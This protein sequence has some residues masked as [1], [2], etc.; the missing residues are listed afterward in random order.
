MKI[1]FLF[2]WYDLWVGIFYDRKNRWIY[3]L[4]LPTVGIILK[5]PTPTIKKLNIHDVSLSVCEHPTDKQVDYHDWSILCTKCNCIISQFGKE[6]NPP[7]K[8]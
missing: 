5:L 3:L 6:I 2:K 8:L 4:P 7:H 1:Q